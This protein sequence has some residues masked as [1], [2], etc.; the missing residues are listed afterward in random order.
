[1]PLWAWLLAIGTI[2]PMLA[3]L[4]AWAITAGGAMADRD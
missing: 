3:F 2:V 4:F 1:M